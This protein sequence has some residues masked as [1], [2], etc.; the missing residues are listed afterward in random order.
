MRRNVV[1]FPNAATGFICKAMT[2]DKYNFPF[3]L[4]IDR[5]SKSVHNHH[6]PVV[7]SSCHDGL[8]F[9]GFSSMILSFHVL[10][11]FPGSLVTKRIGGSISSYPPLYLEPCWSLHQVNNKYMEQTPI[12][13]I[14]LENSIRPFALCRVIRPSILNVYRFI[15]D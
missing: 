10:G 2:S 4:S 9:F 15:S 11:T 1:Q 3:Q 5:C 6:L 13:L 12:P 14:S 8:N 7:D